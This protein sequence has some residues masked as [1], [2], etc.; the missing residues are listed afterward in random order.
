MPKARCIYTMIIWN[1]QTILK[2]NYHNSSTVCLYYQLK[3]TNAGTELGGSSNTREAEAGK[4][5]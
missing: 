3:Y 2:C 4:S 1:L 5:L